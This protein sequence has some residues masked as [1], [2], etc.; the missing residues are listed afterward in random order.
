MGIILKSN[1]CILM[2]FLS[3]YLKNSFQWNRFNPGGREESYCAHLVDSWYVYEFESSYTLP[4]SM[5]K[6]SVFV[7]KYID[8]YFGESTWIDDTTV[9]VN[10]IALGNNMQI[11]FQNFCDI[12]AIG[13]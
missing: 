6:I 12:L 3:E 5:T 2:I 7:S 13:Y 11:A 9:N 1:Q 4:L 8:G 10:F